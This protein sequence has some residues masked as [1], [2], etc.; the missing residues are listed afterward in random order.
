MKTRKRMKKKKTVS[1][2][3]LESPVTTHKN[4]MNVFFLSCYYLPISR[5]SLPRV[6]SSITE[7]T[8]ITNYTLR[9]KGR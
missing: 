8:R 5:L 9:L 6:I 3:S 7:G 2:P 4:T 1:S